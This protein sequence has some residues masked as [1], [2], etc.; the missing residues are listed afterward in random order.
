MLGLVQAKPLFNRFK[1]IHF[2][3]PLFIE[4]RQK[5]KKCSNLSY[6]PKR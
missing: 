1:R 5:A 2:K 3:P 6:P 4:E